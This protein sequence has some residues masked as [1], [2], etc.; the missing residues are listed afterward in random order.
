M[1]G[2]NSCIFAYGQACS[3]ALL[4]ADCVKPALPD[5]TFMCL[6]MRLVHCLSRK[7]LHVPG[8]ETG[9]PQTLGTRLVWLCC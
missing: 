6:A 8:H 3:S 9:A 7:H 1:S 2:Y 5:C 4:L